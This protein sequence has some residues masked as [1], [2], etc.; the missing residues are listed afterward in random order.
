MPNGVAVETVMPNTAAA[1]SGL[2]FGDLLIALDNKPISNVNHLSKFFKSTSNTNFTLRIERIAAN[3]VFK[4]SDTMKEKDFNQTIEA[5]EDDTYQDFIL[6]ENKEDQGEHA[7]NVKKA[8][9]GTNLDKMK[10]DVVPKIMSNEN[11]SKFAQSIGTFSLRKRKLAEKVP[12][13]DKKL[14]THNST[15]HTGEFVNKLVT[16]ETS[17]GVKNID[18]ELFPNVVE[19]FKSQ[20][21]PLNSIITLNSE[22]IFN[23]NDSSNY[24][25]INV[26]GTSAERDVLLGYLNVSISKILKECSSSLLGHYTRIFS[27][28][29]PSNAQPT[30]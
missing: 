23:L 7:E 12:N 11:M 26:W 3:Y 19:I 16:S 29:P 30:T 21:F 22:H 13:M 1:K 8:K 9:S 10:G 20:E 17:D 5:L 15:L 27:F 18:G 24:L 6:L 4:S 14:N 25:N 28:L 2:M